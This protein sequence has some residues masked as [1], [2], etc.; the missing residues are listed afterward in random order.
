MGPKKDLELKL[1][2]PPED[3]SAFLSVLRFLFDNHV[4]SSGLRYNEIDRESHCFAVVNLDD[5]NLDLKRK[6]EASS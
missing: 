2:G 1:T 4:F 3:V 6:M 5:L